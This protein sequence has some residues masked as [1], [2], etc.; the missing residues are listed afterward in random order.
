MRHESNFICEWLVLLLSVRLPCL[1]SS[2]VLL[3]RPLSSERIGSHSILWILLVLVLLELLTHIWLEL[4]RN[5]SSTHLI[6][7]ALP[8]GIELL[9]AI[10][11][12]LNLWPCLH[13]RGQIPISCWIRITH[14]TKIEWV[15][16]VV[17]E[18][19]SGSVCA[20]RDIRVIQS[21]LLEHLNLLLDGDSLGHSLLSREHEL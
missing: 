17:I 10:R 12:A 20:L 11:S 4:L 6:G 14:P 15:V 9:S 3:L 16:R 2:L 18:T 1:D 21:I 13:G 19:S 5:H 8:S 7:L